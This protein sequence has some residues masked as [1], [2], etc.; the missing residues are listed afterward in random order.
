M[1]ELR[2]SGVDDQPIET[3]FILLACIIAGWFMGKGAR[4]KLNHQRSAIAWA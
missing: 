4:C 2:A 3:D 1:L